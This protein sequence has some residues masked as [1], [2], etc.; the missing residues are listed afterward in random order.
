MKCLIT[1]AAG[2]VGTNLSLRLLENGHEVIGA[3][4]LSRRGSERNLSE[5]T[6][7]YPDFR[8]EQKEIEDIPAFIFKNSPQIVYHFAAQVAVTTSVTNPVRDFDINAR[9]TFNVAHAANQIG[10]PVIYTSTNK[11]YG[12]NVNHV[13]ITELEKRYDFD[14]ELHGKGISESFPID[15]F[16]HTPYGCSK[17]VGDI[18][19]REFGGVVNRCS[20]MYGP[21]QF[22]ISDQGWLAYF[23]VKMLLKQP[24]TIFG[25]GKQVRDALHAED[26][27]RLLEMQGIRLLDNSKP[28]IQ[29]NVFNIGGG[30]KNTISLLELCDRWNIKPSFSEW[31][32]ADQKVFYCDISKAERV[33][34]WKP[35]VGLDQ[36]LENLL[37]WA[38][39]SKKFNF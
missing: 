16:H 10:V 35:Q 1:G 15:S 25:D 19:V 4:S 39:A 7:Q 32:S 31:R 36:G 20:C 27:S 33:L 21:N 14:G 2:F 8:F 23:A 22:G 37:Q 24:I 17:L 26:V 6:N 30:Y 29:G 38:E 28:S 34:G 3:D 5:L 12:D 13:P 11:V 9:G 18:Y